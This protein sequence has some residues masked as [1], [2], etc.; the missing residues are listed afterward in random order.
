[1]TS[2]TDG[3]G[4]TTQYEYNVAGQVRAIVDPTGERETYLYDGEDRLISRHR[5]QRRDG[6]DGL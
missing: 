6:G 3:E 4:H 2:S 5:P 1:M